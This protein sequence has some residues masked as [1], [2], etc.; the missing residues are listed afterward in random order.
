MFSKL[1]PI[2]VILFI[3]AVAGGSLWLS[4]DDGTDD[5]YSKTV[6]V[7]PPPKTPLVLSAATEPPAAPPHPVSIRALREKA[8]N[9][10]ELKLGQ[11]LDDTGEYTRYY[12]TYLSGELTISGIMNVPQG[13]GPF[14]ALVLNH[15]HIDT[16][17][18]TNGRG[19]RRE[20]DY[21][22]R[23]GFVVLHTDYRNHA[24]SSRDDRDAL[25]VRLS[26]AEDAINAVLALKNSGLAYIDG[27]RIGMLGHSMGG[28]V[29]LAA[30]VSKTGLVDAAVLYAPVSGDMRRS[31]ERWIARQS[32]N[33]E[34]I[35]EL[36][37]SPEAAPAFWDNI[38]AETFYSSITVP[39]RIFHGTR[40]AS[41]P[42][43]WSY[44]TFAKLESAGAETELTVFDGE[45]HEFGPEWGNF[46]ANT[47]DFFNANLLS[48][49]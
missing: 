23:N 44:D 48:G 8:Y 36:Y 9:G 43:E 20:Q 39:V 31:Y 47:R 12:V 37:G 21:L 49:S 22:A 34:Q 5:F 45:A 14:P 13:E 26:Y 2:A 38:S 41:V 33:V 35:T 30:L 15:G 7:E 6:T 19:L 32:N 29:T 24:D 4:R 10:S 1:V 40:D 27:D 3:V 46:M 25:A 17:I 42:I 18:Y 28:G 11:V 16:S